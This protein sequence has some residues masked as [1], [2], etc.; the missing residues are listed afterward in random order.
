MRQY[1]N[2]SKRYYGKAIMN[3][4]GIISKLQCNNIVK[5]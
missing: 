5:R 1:V 2:A 4:Y 3:Y